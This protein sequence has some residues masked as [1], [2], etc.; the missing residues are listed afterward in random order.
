VEGLARRLTRLRRTAF[1]PQGSLGCRLKCPYRDTLLGSLEYAVEYLK[2]PLIWVR[3]HERSEAVSAAVEKVS[4]A[5]G[6]RARLVEV[7]R[8]AVEE[9]RRQSG[10]VLENAICANSNQV[11]Q[12]LRTTSWILEERLGRDALELGGGYRHPLGYGRG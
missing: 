12:P 2:A 3:G 4:G 5:P 11:R 6:H 1:W 10:D 8:T 9:A 7:L